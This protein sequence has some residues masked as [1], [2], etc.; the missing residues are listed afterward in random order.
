[1]NVMKD[2]KEKAIALYNLIF[3]SIPLPSSL[4]SMNRFDY[5]NA[6]IVEYLVHH[7]RYNLINDIFTSKNEK[8]SI[9]Q[10]KMFA[11][12]LPS[13][14]I[15]WINKLGKFCSA[16]TKTDIISHILQSRLTHEQSKNLQETYVFDWIVN[17]TAYDAY[18]LSKTLLNI[19]YI[20]R[21]ERILETHMTYYHIPIYKQTQTTKNEQ[22][23]LDKAIDIQFKLRKFFKKEKYKHLDFLGWQ[24]T[25]IICVFLCIKEDFITH[26]YV[27]MQFLRLLFDNIESTYHD[28]SAYDLSQKIKSASIVAK[29]LTKYILVNPYHRVIGNYIGIFLQKQSEKY[30]NESMLCDIFKNIIK[31]DQTLGVYPLVSAFKQDQQMKEVYE[32]VLAL[33]TQ[34]QCRM[35]YLVK[36]IQK[37]IYLNMASKAHEKTHIKKLTSISEPNWRQVL[38]KIYN[39]KSSSKT[40]QIL[41]SS[42]EFYDYLL[43]ITPSKIDEQLQKIQKIEGKLAFNNEESFKILENIEKLKQD[44][45]IMKIMQDCKDQSHSKDTDFTINDLSAYQMI[46]I[47]RYIRRYHQEYYI[48]NYNTEQIQQIVNTFSFITTKLETFFYEHDIPCTTQQLPSESDE[49]LFAV[50]GN[51]MW[52]EEHF[53]QQGINELFKLEEEETFQYLRDVENKD[54]CKKKESETEL[55]IFHM[56]RSWCK[57]AYIDYKDDCKQEKCSERQSVELNLLSKEAAKNCM[58]KRKLYARYCNKDPPDDEHIEQVQAA[59]D[60]YFNCT[61]VLLSKVK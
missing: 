57:Q 19:I 35:F 58:I 6:L 32:K 39:I 2:T 22:S 13:Q 41:Q 7:T 53:S 34:L 8:I 49:N 5:T 59:E 4:K 9:L 60:K 46:Y 47:Q 43:S 21:F 3:K 26:P 56:T 23:I 31:F 30:F 48:P 42:K 17:N 14:H 29:V 33:P 15:I 11:V 50:K 1:M 25:Y 51:E 10:K 61:K 44:Y 45:N 54:K 18:F 28:R 40:S 20:Q 12:T 36:S 52:Y 37:A 16:D 24:E 38:Q 27:T 55:D